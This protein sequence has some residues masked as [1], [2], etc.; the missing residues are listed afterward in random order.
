MLLTPQWPEEL[1]YAM[2]KN[3][4]GP[5]TFKG[6]Y[7]PAI[8]DHAGTYHGSIIQF[9]NKWIAFYHSKILSGNAYCRSLMA[10][11]LH[12]NPDGTIIPIQPSKEGISNGVTPKC[13]ILLE[14]E[15]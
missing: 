12:Y 2:S 4:L 3:P 5:F 15:S 9:K 8:K 6:K 14:A 13:K 10:D 11:W 7:V 1:Y